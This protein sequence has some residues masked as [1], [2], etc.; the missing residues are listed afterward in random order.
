MNVS[1]SSCR[2]SLLISASIF[3]VIAIIIV[4]LIIPPVRADTFPQAIPEFA[5]AVFWVS[6]LGFLFFAAALFLIAR[7]IPERGLTG[8]M[9]AIGVFTFILATVLWD[10]AG[11]FQGHGADLRTAV[12]MMLICAALGTLASILLIATVVLL[13]RLWKAQASQTPGSSRV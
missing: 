10:P 2:L 11:A 5:A 4:T 3:A 7:R 6:A 9:F 1:L 8:C 12:S 13:R